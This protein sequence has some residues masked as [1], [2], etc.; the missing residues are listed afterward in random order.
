MIYA[1][2]RK[3]GKLMGY[4]RIITCTLT[5]ESGS[6]LRAVGAT[7]SAIVTGGGWNR[8]GR[9]RQEQPIYEGKKI[10]WDL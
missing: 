6:S 4:E 7:E 9:T 10:R 5:T 2:L 8:K 1:R 3:I